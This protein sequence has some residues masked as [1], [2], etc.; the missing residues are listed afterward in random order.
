M[1]SPAVVYIY[2]CRSGNWSAGLDKPSAWVYAVIEEDQS[3]DK[4]SSYSASEDEAFAAFN[5]SD[6]TM[7]AV[8]LS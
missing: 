1:N 2:Q 3:S 8:R 5:A 6:F 7:L 4:E